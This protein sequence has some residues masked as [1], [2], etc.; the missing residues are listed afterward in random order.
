M[1]ALLDNGV[2]RAQAVEALAAS[3]GSVSKA[4]LWL[5]EKQLGAGAA[6]TAGGT[7]PLAMRELRANGLSEEDA[8]AALEACG[9]KVDEAGACLTRVCQVLMVLGLGPAPSASLLAPLDFHH[10]ECVPLCVCACA[11]SSLM[12]VL[13]AQTYFSLPCLV[14]SSGPPILH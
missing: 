12:F 11:V 1:A 6:G 10:A 4:E 14:R 9:G 2:T 7:D 13:T 3:G 8:V 5:I